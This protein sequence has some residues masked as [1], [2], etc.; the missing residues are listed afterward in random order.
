MAR[1]SSPLH[2]QMGKTTFRDL[3]AWKY[4][5]D[6]CVEVYRAIREL[7]PDE[8]FGLASQMR[9]AAVSIA[10]NIAEGQGR[11]AA[12]D[13]GQFLSHARGSLYELEAQVEIARALQLISIEHTEALERRVQ[14]LG[15]VL[16]GLMR[17]VDRRRQQATGNRQ[18]SVNSTP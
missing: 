5:L 3:N 4:A 13:W 17:W 14:T 7:P 18:H 6:L 15:R 10:S 8:R 11:R 9:R 2:Q 1:R 16:S 12:G